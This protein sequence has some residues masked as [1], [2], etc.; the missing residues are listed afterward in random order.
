MVLQPEQHALV[1]SAASWACLS[2]Q[3]FMNINSMM[4]S[5]VQASDRSRVD[6]SALRP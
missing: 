5:L 4:I 3:P 2:R 1:I 6:K